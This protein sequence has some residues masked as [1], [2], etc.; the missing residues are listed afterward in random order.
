MTKRYVILLQPKIGISDIDGED[1]IY[2]DMGHH[3]GMQC[4]HNGDTIEHE[5]IR[6][7]CEEVMV[8]MKRIDELNTI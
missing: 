3:W 7:L 6:K 2:S 1:L 5:A 8:R 4:N